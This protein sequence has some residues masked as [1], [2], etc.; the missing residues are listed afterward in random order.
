[1]RNFFELKGKTITNIDGL[2]FE[3]QEYTFKLSDGTLVKF[4]HS[5]DC[6]E[7][8]RVVKINGSASSVIGK[9]ITLAEED[10]PIEFGD[11]KEDTD[12]TITVF[13]IQVDD[14]SALEV[15]W[16]GESNG[17][18]SE[19]VDVSFKGPNEESFK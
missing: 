18:Y 2:E 17:F 1:M 6:C 8:V 4:D 3:S 13:K 16:L 11:I 14:G 7:Y 10:N 5:Q 19:D 12:Q 15:V 9:P